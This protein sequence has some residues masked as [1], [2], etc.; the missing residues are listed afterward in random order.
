[1]AFA[2]DVLTII[3]GVLILIGVCSMTVIVVKHAKWLGQDTNV[4]RAIV[5]HYP[6]DTRISMINGS[7][8]SS[9]APINASNFDLISEDSESSQLFDHDSNQVISKI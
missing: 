4:E 3:F 2:G 1:M 9:T 8:S 6:L 7:V 5:K